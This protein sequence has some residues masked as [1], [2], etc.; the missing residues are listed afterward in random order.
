MKSPAPAY[1]LSHVRQYYG[2]T[3]VLDIDELEIRAG[4]ITGLIGP[5][6]SGKTTLLKLLAFADSPGSGVIMYKGRRAEPFSPLIRSKVTLLTQKPYLL[7][8]SVFDNIAY[9]LKIRRDTENLETRIKKAL[10]A[11]GLSYQEF[12]RRRSH[13]LSGGEAQR[14]ALAARLVLEPEVLLLDEPVASV[15]LKSAQLIR[16][17]ALAARKTWGTTLVIASHDL[18]W[19]ASICD[20]RISIFK[21][22]IFA[23]GMEN[24][25]T[26]P[27]EPK[28]CGIAEKILNDGQSIR[29]ESPADAEDVSFAVIGTGHMKIATDI[30]GPHTGSGP[31]NRLHGH[32]VSMLLERKTG[33][34]TAGVAVS[35]LSFVVRLSP[36]K[37]HDLNLYPG[38][39]IILEFSPG[40]AAWF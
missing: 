18:A 6:G 12:A 3:K 38:K 37:I 9:G 36:E 28:E 16:Q 29:L 34:I 8:R 11:V 21:G 14:V 24:I 25:I 35:E 26:G 27:F 30:D 22:R 39:N 33:Y 15:D 13:E 2:D 20:T 1:R 17:A 7:R 19:L 5:N 10:A 4:S 23:T 31:S 32:V 40:H